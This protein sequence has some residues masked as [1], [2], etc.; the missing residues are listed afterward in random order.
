M[1]REVM[2][3]DL[4]LG[5]DEEFYEAMPQAVAVP[6]GFGLPG[7][8]GIVYFTLLTAGVVASLVLISLFSSREISVAGARESL[9]SS[10]GVSSLAE[11]Q[12]TNEAVLSQPTDQGESFQFSRASEIGVRAE[13]IQPVGGIQGRY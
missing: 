2:A 3:K 5:R 13:G 8:E 4:D 9:T 12:L 6:Q 11:P 7:L 10:P 1:A